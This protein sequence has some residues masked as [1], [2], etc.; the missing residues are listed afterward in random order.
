MY[1]TPSNKKLARK[2][3]KMIKKSDKADMKAYNKIQKS[4]GLEFEPKARKRHAKPL[5]KLQAKKIK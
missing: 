4:T 5:T 2:E 1:K 3:N